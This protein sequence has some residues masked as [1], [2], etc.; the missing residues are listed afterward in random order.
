MVW[1]LGRSVRDRENCTGQA[2]FGNLRP[3]TSATWYAADLA[4]GDLMVR[5]LPLYVTVQTGVG[6]SGFGAHEPSL[7]LMC[8]LILGLR[9]QLWRPICGH[10]FKDY[11]KVRP[12]YPMCFEGGIPRGRNAGIFV[13][14]IDI[15]SC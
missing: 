7:P 10:R 3:M 1:T 11:D 8:R 4:V 12:A 6:T 9:R 15:A 13:G 5:S 14:N 2:V